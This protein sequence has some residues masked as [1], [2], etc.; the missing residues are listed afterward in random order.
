M[1][2]TDAVRAALAARNATLYA[3]NRD[4]GVNRSVLRRFLAGDGIQSVHLDKLADYLRLEVRPID[5]LPSATKR[6]K[7]KPE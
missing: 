2:I 6:R 3:I 4:T 7:D 1:S 5:E